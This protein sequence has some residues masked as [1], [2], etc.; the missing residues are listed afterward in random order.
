MNQLIKTPFSILYASV[1]CFATTAFAQ[2][3]DAEFT[4]LFDGKT[5]TGWEHHGNWGIE[6]GAFY[7]KEKGGSLTYTA[8]TVPDDFELRFE[9]KVSKG[10][11]SGVYYRPGQVEYQILDNVH[12]PYGENARQAAASIFFCMAPSKDA[13][14]L[15]GEWNTGHI[16]C[17]GTVIEHWLNGER[18]LSFDYADPKWA[19][20][21][22]LLGIRGG[23]LTG[24]GGRLWLQDHGQ[25][26]WY[27]A[28]RW[29]EIPTDERL[30]P[31]PAFKPLPVTGT[32]LAKEQARVK[33]ML[34]AK[35]KPA[36][37]PTNATEAATQKAK[38]AAEL[39]DKYQAWLATLTPAQQ[40]WQRVLQAELGN[41]YL[42]I[43]K[44]QK[45]AGQSNAWDFVEDDPALPRV[46]LI[47]DSVS[48][49]YTQTVRKELA[50]EANVHRAPA[51]CGPTATGLKKID[52]WLGDGKWDL[53]HFNF[54]IHDRNT[55]IEDYTQ[56][57]EQLI[58]RMKQTGA[59]LIWANTTPIPDLP[60]KRYTAA[61]IVERNAAAGA[62]MRKHQIA[63]DDLFGAITPR[64][65][66]LQN[67]DDV[68]F[69]AAGNT[70]LGQQVAR[71]LQPRLRRRFDFSVRAS[72]IN[73]RAKEH[74]EI[75]FVF[76]DAEGQPQ[77]FQHA[78]VD[79]RAP[80]RGRLVIWLM[81][82]NQ[83]LFERIGTYGLH[84]IQPHYANRWFSII[85][86]KAR[87]DGTTLGKIR[88]EAATGEDHS[89]LVTIPKPDGMAERCVQFVKWLAKENPK[90]SWEQ[91]LTDN[92]NDLCWDKVIMSGIS[93]G[94]TTAARFAKHQK[95]ARV[96]MFSGPRDQFESWHGFPSSTPAQRYF[97][98]THVLDGG[99]TGD[100][101]CRSWQMLGLAEYGPIVNVDEVA[102]PYAKSRRLITS[103]DV[104]NNPR[105]AHTTVVPGG[106]AV[107]TEQGEYIH[108]A[109]WRY[110]F[111]HPVDQTG[112][113]VP[114]DPN[115]KIDHKE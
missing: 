105:R 67:P 64:L 80:S 3:K 99:W 37:E 5:F 40:A 54:G 75:G 33:R 62:V 44:R 23:D 7:R 10:C 35:K 69:N 24:R 8:M 94:S 1:V 72:A 71:F 109:V 47:G 9:W 81:R 74:P 27:R 26:V 108:E 111:T 12:S 88:L 14:K 43:H 57:L 103:S 61:S 63:I 70:F 86:A 46:L 48:R 22:K 115:C 107:K 19:D 76:A 98:F 89:P 28:L 79:T 60:A 112:K 84:G 87:D 96:V 21:V 20:Y 56:R 106:S 13:S 58:A 59:T 39:D 52:V 30:T 42:P 77:D 36:K 100:H 15:F 41:F 97:G 104:D 16:L 78:V 66:E 11:N 110:L 38:E 93:H 31:D 4:S 32:A 95:V 68:H 51:N 73:P 17:K 55:P 101:Y 53:I 85:H 102:T 2:T 92:Q 29:R 18:V 6:D 83:G 90:G 114:L 45:I 65:A 34:D 49:A 113:P 50:G 82:H 91:F 25:D